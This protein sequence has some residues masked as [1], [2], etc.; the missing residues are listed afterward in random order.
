MDKVLEG[1]GAAEEVRVKN[2]INFIVFFAVY[3]VREGTG[4]VRAMSGR[5]A[6]GR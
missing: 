6:I 3:K 5:F 1:F 4:K 2:G